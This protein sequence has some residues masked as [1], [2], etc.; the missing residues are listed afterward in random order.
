MSCQVGPWQCGA[1]A[2]GDSPNLPRSVDFCA[3]VSTTKRAPWL[4][5]M[6]AANEAFKQRRYH[7]AVAGFSASL[8]G[9]QGRTAGVAPG[10]T[11]AAE[12]STIY[13]NRCAACLYGLVRTK[14]SAVPLASIIVCLFLVRA[15][16]LIC[17]SPSGRRQRT[18][19]SSVFT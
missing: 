13:L 10:G 7:D 3:P 15:T 1:A 6:H 19:Q 5:Y 11:T 14:H 8:T 12:R 4:E 9:A 18:T 17:S 2:G 16:R